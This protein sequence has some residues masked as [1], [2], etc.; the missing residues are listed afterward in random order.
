MRDVK[1]EQGAEL[2]KEWNG[3]WETYKGKYGKEAEEF[4][5]IMTGKLPADWAKC[6]PTFSPED[7]GLATRAHSQARARCSRA[8]SVVNPSTHRSAAPLMQ[9]R[10]LVS[11]P[12]GAASA[13]SALRSPSCVPSST[14]WARA[15][16]RGACQDHRGCALG[17]HS[18]DCAAALGK[19]TLRA[20][21]MLHVIAPAIRGFIVHACRV[22]QERCA[23]ARRRC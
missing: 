20:Q 19:T 4:E 8:P 11:A 16:A 7:K 22:C 6:L 17:T 1:V 2:E 23:R 9:P 15:G 13:L 18:C 12:L 21:T 14:A 10:T 5:A 3:V